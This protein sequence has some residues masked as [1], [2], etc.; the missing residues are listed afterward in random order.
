M[1]EMY[2]KLIR[3]RIPET[4]QSREVTEPNIIR[5]REP[6]E[7]RELLSDKLAEEATEYTLAETREHKTDKLADVFEVLCAYVQV[8]DY[9]PE[10]LLRTWQA[11]RSIG[12]ELDV[13]FS[14]INNSI[15]QS[16]S[17]SERLEMCADALQVIAKCAE[18]DYIRFDD[19][20]DARQQKLAERGGFLD[21]VVML[22]PVQ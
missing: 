10:L 16:P 14:D 1:N 17:A 12:S 15:R 6:S 22:K 5:V 8:D 21:G 19:I 3:H 9:T 4:I 13:S 2:P 7:L 20:C 11:R 18:K